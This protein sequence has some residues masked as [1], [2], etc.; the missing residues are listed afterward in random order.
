MQVRKR[1]GSIEA[2]MPEKIVVSI[3]K[4]GAPYETAREIA[5][6][7]SERTEAQLDTSVI[8]E[9]VL[10]QLKRRGHE[11]SVIHWREYDARKHS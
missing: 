11:Q 2:F 6:T 8:R 7:I 3:V 5:A 10:D 1:D 9:L 4:S